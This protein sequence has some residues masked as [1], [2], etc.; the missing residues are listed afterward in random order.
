[1]ADNPVSILFGAALASDAKEQITKQIES[2]G[3]DAKLSPRLADKALEQMSKDVSAALIKGFKIDTILSDSMKNAIRN[4]LSEAN[5]EFGLKLKIEDLDLSE[6]DKSIGTIGK[7]L[8]KKIGESTKGSPTQHLQGLEQ[9]YEK[10]SE[11]AMAFEKAAQKALAQSTRDIEKRI[12]AVKKLGDAYADYRNNPD[13]LADVGA[14]LSTFRGAQESGDGMAAAYAWTQLERS[15]ALAE[16]KL[17]SFKAV[18][19]NDATWDKLAENIENVLKKFDTFNGKMDES[20]KARDNFV[21]KFAKDFSFGADGV[22]VSDNVDRS[23]AHYEKMSA[24]V[25]DAYIE[26]E[27]LESAYADSVLG[28]RKTKGIERLNNL[29]EITGAFKGNA[30]FLRQYDD[31]L[32]NFGKGSAKSISLAEKQMLNF[33]QELSKTGMLTE[34]LGDRLNNMFT[35]FTQWFSVSQ[36][37]MGVVNSVKSAGRELIGVDTYLT[38]ISKSSDRAAESLSR[39]KNT[40]FADANSLGQNVKN[41]LSAAQEF[42]RA[43]FNTE[44]KTE[45]LAK[46]SLLTQTAGDVTA[47]TANKYL[48]AT[49]AAYNYQGS[50]EKLNAVLDSQNQVTNRNAVNLTDLAE[51]TSIVGSQAAQTGIGI[52]QLTAALATIIS[53]TQQDAASAARGFRTIIMGLSEVT[54]ELDD[55]SQVTV[56]DVKKIEAALSAVGVQM[57]EIGANGEVVLRPTMDV[58]ADLQEAFSQLDANSIERANIINAFG[59]NRSNTLVALLSNAETYKKILGDYQNAGGSAAAEAAKTAESVQGRL[60]TIANT[61]LSIV[62]KFASPDAMKTILSGIQGI[63]NAI[64]GFASIGGSLSNITALGALFLSLSQNI[65]RMM[66]LIPATE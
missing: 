22:K 38:E 25:R 52:D 2:I 24:A 43:G 12:A 64:N 59:K 60:N 10:A 29:K 62:D 37:V 5:G 58:V 61:W 48:I 51:A 55:G 36:I 7:K 33:R 42:S 49:N 47:E 1:M 8:Q 34:S 53:T 35:K 3:V 40:G 26:V 46:L 13:A 15:I 16:D 45:D 44:G 66:P 6:I 28:L 18:T 23:T 30:D 32:A 50:V 39:L 57:K 41:Y 21:E 11:A 9:E 54:G 14:K 31:I 17:E 65:G 20:I 56:E 27:R 19:N 63:L 4:V